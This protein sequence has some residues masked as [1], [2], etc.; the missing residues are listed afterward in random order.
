LN[1]ARDNRR[2]HEA[3]RDD[4][5]AYALGALEEGEATELRRH[6][7]GCEECREHLRWLEPA[8]DV[9]PRTVPQVEPPPRLRRR[10]MATVRA[11]SREATRAQ[12][13]R[14]PRR[15][16]AA[17]VLRPATAAAAAAL[18]LAGAL[19]GY[20]L[21]SPTDRSSVV[22]AR[23]TNAAPAASGTLERQ[24][25]VA[26]LH[27]ERMPALARDQVYETW[28]QRDGRVE[29][30]SVFTLRNNRS[31]EAAIP[32]SLHGADAVLVTKEPAG[33]SPQPT[34]PPVL[35]ADLG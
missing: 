32:G 9:L 14:A 16:W 23:P 4:L 29:P 22:A 6:L 31:G 12:A 2:A 26:I 19:G 25:D 34:S 7:E 17:L 3:Y 21:H 24:E 35:E 33:G 15:D 8:V 20:L 10:M 11:E 27:V 1:G 28:V 30:S 18:L 5:A 13:R